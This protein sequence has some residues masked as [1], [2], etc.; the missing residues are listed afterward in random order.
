MAFCPKCGNQAL[1]DDLFCD[2]CGQ[3]LRRTPSEPAPHPIAPPPV[4][5]PAAPSPKPLA[6]LDL[7][8]G[9]RET[10]SFLLGHIDRWADGVSKQM[11]ILAIVLLAS[12]FLPW[13]VA[14]DSII[15]KMPGKDGNSYALWSWD[16]P[17]I[18][19]SVEEGMEGVARRLRRHGDRK[20]AKA[21]ED[22][23]IPVTMMPTFLLIM[24]IVAGAVAFVPGIHARYK[25]VGALAIVTL[26]FVL[27]G[28]GISETTTAGARSGTVGSRLSMLM[29][30]VLSIG[31]TG[32]LLR[33]GRTG[34]SAAR[35][36]A[37]LGVLLVFL[38]LVL[39]LEL[40]GE[41]KPMFGWFV[42]AMD[43]LDG[44]EWPLFL[45]LIAMPTGA[46]A[47]G[48]TTLVRVFRFRERG[49]SLH[50]PTE[51]EAPRT[52]LRNAQ[53]GRSIEGAATILYIY[54]MLLIVPLIMFIAEEFILLSGVLYL[55]IIA[56][57]QILWAMGLM[58]LAIAGVVNFI[59]GSRPQSSR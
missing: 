34:W 39:P 2:S 30:G 52:W 45:A 59:A 5:P 11:R 35:F 43:D 38:F 28:W 55:A 18:Y 51:S 53:V 27:G 22:F 20:E 4:T 16:M 10:Q 8:R 37:P 26:W 29:I 41:S 23:S 1:D 12:F 17:K 3:K 6:T 9:R 40:D 49:I 36:T 14:D 19:E 15:R 31:L 54:I 13:A 21:L 48:L 47:L 32:S 44:K 50:G 42:E 46:F 33:F 58:G 25:V 7:Q 24:G 57:I 56:G